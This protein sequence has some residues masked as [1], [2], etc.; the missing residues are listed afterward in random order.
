MALNHVVDENLNIII[1]TAWK[2]PDRKLS[3]RD[4]SK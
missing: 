4:E 1:Y 2:C 3:G